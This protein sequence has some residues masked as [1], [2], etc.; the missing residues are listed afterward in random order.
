MK[1]GILI[2]PGVVRATT[3]ALAVAFLALALSTAPEVR[4]YLRLKSM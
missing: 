4:R 2:P 3:A 1:N